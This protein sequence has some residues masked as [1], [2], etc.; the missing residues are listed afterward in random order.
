LSTG[1][2]VTLSGAGWAGLG[3]WESPMSAIIACVA[4]AGGFHEAVA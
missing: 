4:T 1:G 3:V 2:G